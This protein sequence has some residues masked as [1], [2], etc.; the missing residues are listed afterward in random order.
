VGFQVP[1]IPLGD[2]VARIGAEF[3]LHK[4]KLVSKSGIISGVM[5]T[6]KVEVVA[7]CPVFGVKI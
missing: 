6:D 3:P 1:V 5:L 4:V 7:H 2:V